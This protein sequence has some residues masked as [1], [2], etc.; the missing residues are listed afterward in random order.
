MNV[1]DG[2]C[3]KYGGAHIRPCWGCLLLTAQ[4]CMDIF[5]MARKRLCFEPNFLKRAYLRG[6]SA[7]GL[8]QGIKPFKEEPYKIFFYW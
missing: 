6:H 8:L 2:V 7:G 1:N 4:I 3:L 5:E